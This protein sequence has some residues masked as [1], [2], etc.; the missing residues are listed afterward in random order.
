MATK[1]TELGKVLKQS[2]PEAMKEANIASADLMNKV[3]ESALAKFNGNME[4]LLQSKVTSILEK[5]DGNGTIDSL[6]LG[7]QSAAMNGE[8]TV[9]A[10]VVNVYQR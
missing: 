10:G 2:I 1:D 6:D 7:A 8:M 5:I 3:L 4:A 9:S